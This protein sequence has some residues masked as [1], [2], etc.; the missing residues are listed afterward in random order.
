MLR[1]ILIA[2][3]AAAMLLVTFTPDDADARGRGGGGYRG[4]GGAYRGGAVAVRGPRGGGAVAVRGGRVA[5]AIEATAIAAAIVATVSVRL[6][7]A[8]LRSEPRRPGPTAAAATTPTA[9]TF[10]PAG[11]V[12]TEFV[13][14]ASCQRLWRVR[15]TQPL[16]DR[17]PRGSQ[18]RSS[19]RCCCSPLAAIKIAQRKPERHDRIP[20]Q[21]TVIS[22]GDHYPLEPN[23]NQGVDPTPN[24]KPIGGRRF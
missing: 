5:G 16:R 23:H 14:A 22:S 20:L 11:T 9:T 17:S 10:A 24:L 4:G 13:A 18:H 19:R 3:A 6:R 7:W 8:P 21:N 12:L 15:L 1:R 2:S